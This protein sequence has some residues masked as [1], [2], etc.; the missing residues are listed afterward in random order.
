MTIEFKN[1]HIFGIE[2]TSDSA[3]GLLKGN[4]KILLLMLLGITTFNY[5]FNGLFRPLSTE[6]VDFVAYYNASLSFRYGSPVYENMIRFFKEGP[7]E[8]KGPLPYVYPP[9]LILILSPLAYLSYGKAV[10][11][12]I[13]INQLFFFGGL[14]LLLKTISKKYS[15]QEWV[16]LVFVSMNFTPLF[17]DYLIGQSNIILFFF[18]TLGLFFYNSK[19]DVYCGAALAIAS[20]IKVIPL[21]LVGYFLWKRQYKVFFS[22]V[23]ALLFFFLYS[24]LFF[25][26]DLYLWYLKFMINQDLFNAYHDNHSFTGFFSRLLIHTVWTTGIADS[27]KIAQICINISSGLTF[28]I[29]LYTTR[30]K[31]DRCNFRVNHEFAFA[32]ITMLLMSKMTSTPYLVMLLVPICVMVHEIFRYR[33]YNVWV[34]LL[35]AAYGILAAWYP[36]PTGKFLEM[37]IYKVYMKGFGVIIF[38]IQFFALL[39]FW[40]YYTLIKLPFGKKSEA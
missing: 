32:I 14:I 31:V 6:K 19:K 8:Y 13:L 21:L 24:L 3:D 18:I 20:M 40:F 30:K 34:L 38:S 22:S 5:I 37:N 39:L 12:W 33:I 2:I 26:V 4:M 28:L 9:W 23:V 1:V 25:D 11:C 16:T 36:L 35:G 27:P 10:L 17:I 7:L 29:F 15:W